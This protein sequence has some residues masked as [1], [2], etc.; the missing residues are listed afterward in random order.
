MGGAGQRDDAAAD[1]RDPGIACLRAVDRPLADSGRAR[2]S[3]A[4]RRRPRVGPAWLPAAGVAPALGGDDHRRAPRRAGAGRLRPTARPAG[5]RRLHRG[6]RR[7]VR[8][9]ATPG[10]P[11]HQRAPGPGQ[12]GVRQRSALGRT[13]SRGT[14]A[15]RPTPA[16]RRRAGVE[17]QRRVDG[18]GRPGLPRSRPAMRS[19]P[20][21]RPLRMAQGRLPA[22]RLAAPAW[23]RLRR[24]RPPGSGRSARDPP[25]AGR[26]GSAGSAAGG[27]DRRRPTGSCAR[28]PSR[29]RPGR[30]AATSRFR[31]PT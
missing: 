14:S 3:C 21:R 15:R 9:P 8:V 19:V 18:A 4:R 30:A 6:R 20:D 25:G 17:V 13:D 24:H 22:V 1:P 5:G 28:R 26:P 31:L 11:R 7:C 27:L 29:R 16:G 10:R 2:G 23:A 12:G